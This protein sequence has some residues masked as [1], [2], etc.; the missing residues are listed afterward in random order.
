MKQTWQI[1]LAVF[2]NKHPALKPPVYA[3]LWLGLQLSALATS[4]SERWERRYGRQVDAAPDS[5]SAQDGPAG[6]AHHR[7]R[8]GLRVVALSL[9]LFVM[10]SQLPSAAYHMEGAPDESVEQEEPPQDSSET[11][12]EEEPEDPP[13]ASEP[14]ADDSAGEENPGDDSSGAPGND[15]SDTGGDS[16]EDSSDNSED[17][18]QEEDPGEEEPKEEPE[19]VII[20]FV[21]LAE[22]IR[23]Q[24]HT[25]GTPLDK[26]QL[27]ARLTAILG[28]PGPA[29][30]GDG[31]E[32]PGE[33][34]EGGES[35]PHS[36][37]EETQTSTAS[38]DGDETSI[39]DESPAPEP[40]SGSDSTPPPA[41]PGDD[42]NA[43]PDA[44][45]E[46]EYLDIPVSWQSDPPYDPYGEGSY[47]FTPLLPQA[48]ALAEGVVL[49]A[50]S[51]AL[52]ESSETMANTLN[53]V[54][55]SA[56]GNDSTG[57]GSK[58]F[59]F[60]SLNKAHEEVIT[61]G[62]IYIKD[63]ITAPLSSGNDRV[64]FSK[65][66]LLTS[67][68]GPHTITRN[69]V[70][71]HFI[72]V[73]GTVTIRNII[74]DGGG[75]ASNGPLVTVG[76]A[77]GVPGTL[78]LENT[79]L[80][81][82]QN[83][84]NTPDSDAGGALFC[85]NGR[86][87]MRG[88]SK[89]IN[90][91]AVRGGAVFVKNSNGLFQLESGT[92]SG[93]TAT[94]N[95]G[96]VFTT[97]YGMFNLGNPDNGTG[98]GLITN[99][100]ADGV[101]NDLYV[102]K[103]IEA[104]RAKFTAGTVGTADGGYY[105]DL[106]ADASGVGGI[107]VPGTNP[108]ALTVYCENI[109]SASAEGPAIATA[110]SGSLARAVAA[111]FLS[112]SGIAEYEL[113]QGIISDGYVKLS[114]PSPIIL[115]FYPEGNA[116]YE[117]LYSQTFA[118]A[119]TNSN[120]G[121]GTEAYITFRKNFTIPAASYSLL[122]KTTLRS[123][124]SSP[125]TVS[126]SGALFTLG[127][128]SPLLV[129]DNITLSGGTAPPI[130]V[131]GGT[132]NQI[133]GT[134]TSSGGGV[135]L[136]GGAYN[137]S[138]GSLSPTGGNNLTATGG[139]YNLS[140]N[141]VVS[142]GT[143]ISLSSGAAMAMSGGTVSGVKVNAGGQSLSM[144]NGS[145]TGGGVV[146]GAGSFLMS[147]GS[148]A[149]SSGIGVEVDAGSFTMS[150]G[151]ITSSAGAGVQVD[152]GSFTLKGSGSIT[153]SGGAGVVVNSSSATAFT[154]EAGSISGN[155]AGPGLHITAGT[156]S[157][158]G[159]SIAGNGLTSGSVSTKA[160]VYLAG[161]T[162]NLEGA[163]VSGAGT[164]ASPGHGIYQGGGNLNI[165]SGTVSGHTAGSGVYTAGGSLS[166]TGGTISGNDTTGNG[167]GIYVGSSA[168]FSMTG[169]TISGNTATG[170]GGGLY[171][172]VA[173]TLG[174]ASGGAVISITGN[175]AQNGGGVYG[176][177][178]LTLQGSATTITSNQAAVNGGGVYS[179]QLVTLANAT[180]GGTG[181]GNSAAAGGGIYAAASGLTFYSGSIIDNEATTTNGG[182]V[183]A[184]DLGFSGG[185]VASNSAEEDGGGIYMTGGA[186][187]SPSS[188]STTLEVKNNNAGQ[189]G[190]GLYLA[191]G[192]TNSYIH[193][194]SFTGNQ[195][196]QHGGGLYSA[197][198]DDLPIGSAIFGGTQAGSNTATGNGGAIY[199]MDS[200]TTLTGTNVSF[201]SAVNGGGIY[202]AA[203]SLTA[204]DAMITDNTAVT[205]GGGL[206]AAAGAT[207]T[208]DTYFWDNAATAGT[209]S[210]ICLDGASLTLD[211]GAVGNGQF[212]NGVGRK[213][214][215]VI[216][217]TANFVGGNNLVVLEKAGGKYASGDPI[218]QST[219]QTTYPDW[220]VPADFSEPNA[221]EAK[222]GERFWAVDD[223]NKPLRGTWTEGE[224]RFMPATI[225]IVYTSL[226]PN[227][228]TYAAT[229]ENA[230][231]LVADKA[232][233]L[234]EQVKATI[235]LGEGVSTNGITVAGNTEITLTSESSGTYAVTRSGN[236]SLFTVNSSASTLIF[237]GVIL[238][239]NDTDTGS[240]VQLTAGSVQLSAA[241]TLRNNNPSGN[242]AAVS[243][244]AG[245][246][247]VNAP[248]FSGMSSA[249]SLIHL[250][251]TA[252]LQLVKGSLGK[253]SL[254]SGSPTITIDD[255]FDGAT[256]NVV[257]AGYS[258]GFAAGHEL[259]FLQCPAG[260]KT[261]AAPCF[262]TAVSGGVLVGGV[263]DADKIIWMDVVVNLAL[264]GSSSTTPH[265]SLAKAFAAIPSSATSAV[266]TLLKD[267]T[268]PTVQMAV[269]A[270]VTIS[271]SGTADTITRASGATGHLIRVTQGT[272][273][274][275]EDLIMDGGGSG[276]GGALIAL[277]SGTS[278]Q[279]EGRLQN[280]INSSTGGAI[281]NNGGTVLLEDGA[282]ITGN[283]AQSGGGIYNGGTLT[284]RTGAAI[285]GNQAQSGGGVYQ[286]GN[287]ASF[288]LSG[289]SITGNKAGSQP[290]T[291]TD[292]SG[293]HISTGGLALAGAPV[294]GQNLTDN[295][296]LN[297]PQ[298]SQ[299]IQLQ[300]SF[301][302]AAR[303]HVGGTASLL[304]LVADAAA[305]L[306]PDGADKAA[307]FRHTGDTG[308]IGQLNE[309][310]DSQVVWGSPMDYPLSFQSNLEFVCDGPMDK[311]SYLLVDGTLMTPGT[312]GNYT[313]SGTTSTSF[314]INS[315]WAGQN[316]PKNSQTGYYVVAVYTD[317]Y[318]RGSANS[319][320]LL[321]AGVTSYH[322]T[323][324]SA[325]G[326]IAA[327]GTGTVTLLGSTT[328]TGAGSNTAPTINNKKV[329]L[330]S[331]GPD[332][333]EAL[334]SVLRGNALTSGALLTL[335]SGATLTLN[336]AVLDGR[337]LASVGGSL[338]ELGSGTTATLN[339]GA[340]LQN[341]R[342]N[343]PGGAVNGSGT[344]VVNGGVI[345]KNAGTLGGAVFLASGGSLTLTS[346]QL[347]ANFAATNGGAI[348]I[349]GGTVSLNGGELSAN[350]TTGQGGAVYQ[351]AGTLNLAGA[352]L[353]G[354][355]AGTYGG[356]ISAVVSSTVNL[357]AGT[358]ANDNI[359]TGGAGVALYL[360]APAV[361][362]LTGGSLAGIALDGTDEDNIQVKSGFAATGAS[363]VLEGYLSSGSLSPILENDLV[364]TYDTA[365]DSNLELKQAAANCFSYG[366]T[367]RGD[368]NS[369]E[370]NVIMAD[371]SAVRLDM[372]GSSSYYSSIDGAM[373]FVTSGKTATI[374][375]LKNLTMQR[376]VTVGTGRSVT[377]SAE[378]G[379]RTATRAQQLKGDLFTVDGGSLTLGLAAKDALT[380]DGNKSAMGTGTGEGSLVH[381]KGGSLTLTI[382]ATLQNNSTNGNGGGVKVTGG[383]FSF[384][385][386]LI[387]GNAA[388]NG[389]GLYYDVDGGSLAL[390]AG[391]LT[392]NT[393]SQNGGGI[394]LARGTLA[395]SG[396]TLS[397]NTGAAGGEVYLAQGA[398]MELSGGQLG[399]G[400]AGRGLHQQ[401]V[402][403]AAPSLTVTG[404]L[405]GT[406][407]ADLSGRLAGS[408]G[409]ASY[410][411]NDLAALFKADAVA[412]ADQLST[413]RRFF[414]TGTVANLN[415][416]LNPDA[417]GILFRRYIE[418]TEPVYNENSTP[419]APGAD[420]RWD[421]TAD[422]GAPSAISVTVNGDTQDLASADYTISGQTLRLTTSYLDN[423]ENGTYAATI[424]TGSQSIATGFTV[425]GTALVE[426]RVAGGAAKP[427]RSLAA[428]ISA[429]PANQAATI[430]P[431]AN[432]TVKPTQAIDGNRQITITGGGYGLTKGGAGNLFTVV[433]G[434]SLIF[435]DITVDG[436]GASQAGGALVKVEG[437]SL[438]LQNDAVLQNNHND[439]DG[440]AVNLTGGSFTMAG[441]EITANQAP[442]G[443]GLA[444]SGGELSLTGGRI[445]QNTATQNGGGVQM[446]G[447]TLT[448]EGVEISGN[449]AVD[450]G[451][452][453]LSA[454]A[455]FTAR[456]GLMVTG[457]SASGQ[458]GGVYL[459][460]NAS[461]TQFG[462]CIGDALLT[463]LDNGIWFHTENPPKAGAGFRGQVGNL[464]LEG[465]TG[466]GATV[467]FGN[468]AVPVMTPPADADYP[469]LVDI[470]EALRYTAQIGGSP[471]VYNAVAIPD[472]A[473][474]FT[475]TTMHD[476]FECFT[477]YRRVES[478]PLV[479]WRF[480]Q[481]HS[482]VDLRKVHVDG[483]LLPEDK[484]EKGSGSIRITLTKAYLHSLKS[485]VY[486]LDA[487]LTTDGDTPS[488][489]FYFVVQRSSGGNQTGSKPGDNG[490][491]GYDGV[492]DTTGTLAGKRG[493]QTGDPTALGPWMLT[494]LAS[495]VSMLTGLLM[496][497]KRR[498]RDKQPE[499]PAEED[500]A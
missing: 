359:T 373:A 309:S 496:L 61:G 62:T 302:A 293:V 201:N 363:Y 78:I 476:L 196:G 260:L 144:T 430:T 173:A 35:S 248:T 69:A 75:L 193:G 345:T 435:D 262:T 331:E 485:G 101:G 22:D 34:S 203:G 344:L 77:S 191:A 321:T 487:Y 452:L 444:V 417:T 437:G 381:L 154:M 397:G 310:D 46:G 461:F 391:G 28:V 38:A 447:G 26:L 170:N 265:T 383:S 470:A 13:E 228:E 161:G 56:S 165:K 297:E 42:S 192:A 254:G 356:G 412:Y 105:T 116:S 490:T 358:V 281:Y 70:T 346:G 164:P 486:L 115:H 110:P 9:A 291:G 372:D 232:T 155:T 195:A 442:N 451:G 159:G 241:A 7:P 47:H 153:T 482:E 334:Y 443:G 392:G 43:P 205:D 420:V 249:G 142:G 385:G 120:S 209:G 111:R 245:T 74:L 83:V 82:N 489:S 448:A 186:A 317:G 398:G 332:G 354:N 8:L 421:L 320:R 32:A 369:S 121:P 113:S 19:K 189:N 411:D 380:L 276:A 20:G 328:I 315:T 160:N 169:G 147:N 166:V 23:S 176:T 68:G 352:T 90:N 347:T 233:A 88:T 287:G 393:A 65:N 319:I 114:A 156:S 219:N 207:L 93:N 261:A 439:G 10:I 458:G 258:T 18:S 60:A 204:D 31:G 441:G 282:T 370:R 355:T 253:L 384:T 415:A 36:N 396:G 403:L 279:L 395:M 473:G 267:I 453:H 301:D 357:S 295:N 316:P 236:G 286:A 79:T 71:N 118:D 125:F 405:S 119:L 259:D 198:N 182:G 338:I 230:F 117:P 150:G 404:A 270:Q 449:T 210:A 367:L 446:T 468:P 244:S 425:R 353:T 127:S 399:S 45:A 226:I 94:D 49:P 402:N 368:V 247:V 211:G 266:I 477:L 172:A 471:V 360:Q 58:D 221:T 499:E 224:I 24:T 498:R 202:L 298:E 280:N 102:G 350:T 275:D 390:A 318:G 467:P 454:D 312:G 92:I 272:L 96:G 6:Q 472:A 408:S 341:N 243:A 251:G 326:G 112:V 185:T 39:S 268:T 136:Q 491:D 351:S 371:A 469:S 479:Y 14:P 50:I 137:H 500:S 99:N 364:A 462:G 459:D 51:V 190:G 132:L 423:L 484:Y 440:G 481:Q 263:N 21:P 89:I 5:P 239:G 483:E 375:L 130:V 290:T 106:A 237:S 25:P 140:G 273:V 194:G 339:T 283:G 429:A 103:V 141:G 167:G 246:L 474:N 41:E 177:S 91:E 59:P 128:S 67:D 431:L 407:R 131:N 413:A 463:P 180:I 72:R 225:R 406:H 218:Y 455:D 87:Y 284:M 445:H 242:G 361:L 434:A 401:L 16:S 330:G 184:N 179:A 37:G 12:P 48:P 84:N 374:T 181:L 257:N 278:L 495:L 44:P 122:R 54:Y 162:L 250:S 418:Y 255:D 238:D 379:A 305:S 362:N 73:T 104:G 342:K 3:L 333:E 497:A 214:D 323:L 17:S 134:I 33:G 143:G 146:L 133:G 349:S 427:F 235:Y 80:Q 348:A 450:G 85:S 456:Q 329:I 285:T 100:T 64:V 428:A 240:L 158:K 274:L 231:T 183:Y 135:T 227:E 86:A 376:R 187:I 223:Q 378:N 422:A 217:F 109:A 252:N 289:G 63:N 145:I 200:T 366:T 271:P 123:E 419:G 322:P 208:G 340:L 53:T 2:A 432:L 129:V 95:G 465:M 57:N 4:L 30:P 1:R 197:V 256:V 457:N 15:D 409:T 212:A 389:G 294:I 55:I 107:T 168:S 76:A 151:S 152:A 304:G 149:S 299:P 335:Q 327:G 365:L 292:G 377:L 269:P 40:G 388:V 148:I 313:V 175:S 466:Q 382:K 336:S 206:Y 124:G 139:S 213:D 480:G 126:Y 426:L 436:G 234:G 171:L 433:S 343:G 188:P 98:S 475:V 215:E 288:S 394:H 386:G 493:P 277:D 174:A 438:T 410:Q 311:F 138:G 178:P 492:Y 81:N 296:L 108:S 400:T 460:E 387:S 464:N 27:P 414:H 478:D 216:H 220:F 66:V 494:A 314:V 308:L 199:L 52:E 303:I 229:L 307:A 157:L 97:D 163:T 416:V 325:I 300:S 11:I 424:T 306:D 488:F 264:N 29:E 337:E 324:N 222:I